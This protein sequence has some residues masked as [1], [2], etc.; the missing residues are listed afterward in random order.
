MNLKTTYK[1]KYKAQYKVLNSALKYKNKS[2]IERFMK[3]YSVDRKMANMLFKDMIRYIW[4]GSFAQIADKNWWNKD[5]SIMHAIPLYQC[6][7]PFDEI[8]HTFILHTADYRDFCNKYFG[9]MIDHN[10][11]PVDHKPRRG[12]K[13]SDLSYKKVQDDRLHSFID[14]IWDALGP[15]VTNRWFIYYGSYTVIM[16]KKIRRNK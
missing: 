7:E 3:D 5:D 13:I 9:R 8:W 6:M 10:P 2:V 15:T 11:T 1:N 4:L 12:E 16:D 14:F